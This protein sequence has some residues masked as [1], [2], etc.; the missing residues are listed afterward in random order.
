M[1]PAISCN[2]RVLKVVQEVKFSGVIL[3]VDCT[4]FQS[5]FSAFL[6]IALVDLWV[7]LEV[8][9]GRRGVCNTL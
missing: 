9:W 6:V 2:G 4:S 1:K 5:S 8:K 7:G 3:T